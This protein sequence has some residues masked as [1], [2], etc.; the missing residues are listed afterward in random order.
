MVTVPSICAVFAE[1]TPQAVLDATEFPTPVSLLMNAV[2]AEEME[3]VPTKLLVL[4]SLVPS[5]V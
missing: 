2:I 4:L 1:E 5:P 3:T